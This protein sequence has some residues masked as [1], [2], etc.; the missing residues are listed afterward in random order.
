MISVKVKFKET[1]IYSIGQLS[2]NGKPLIRQC[3][4]V[5]A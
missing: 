4:A 3:I 1:L 5:L 2:V